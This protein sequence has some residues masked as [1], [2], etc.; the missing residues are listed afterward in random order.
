M[1]FM[2]LDISQTPD[3]IAALPFP[4]TN[5]R[6]LLQSPPKEFPLVRTK[7][8]TA[9]RTTSA[10]VKI[11]R[12]VFDVVHA[13]GAEDVLWVADGV[14]GGG[15][16]ETDWG[17]EEVNLI[18]RRGRTTIG[19]E[20]SGGRTGTLEMLR[21]LLD[22]AIE[23]ETHVV[24]ENRRA[25]EEEKGWVGG[26]RKR[27]EE[28][29]R[30][31]RTCRERMEVIWEEQ[32]DNLRETTEQ[33]E[34]NRKRSRGGREGS[35]G[36]RRTKTR[37]RISESSSAR[38]RSAKKRRGTISSLVVLFFLAEKD[39]KDEDAFCLQ[40]DDFSRLLR[41]T[42]NKHSIRP[43]TLEEMCV[44]TS[45]F[46]TSLPPHS[47]ALFRYDR[48][49][50]SWGKSSRGEVQKRDDEVGCSFVKK[51]RRKGMVEGREVEE[52]VGSGGLV[53][54]LRLDNKHFVV[55]ILR[56][57]TV[58]RGR[59]GI[60]PRERLRRRGLR[61][62]STKGLDGVA[63]RFFLLCRGD[64]CSTFELSDLLLQTSDLIVLLRNRRLK[65]RNLGRRVTK[66]EADLVALLLVD[67]DTLASGLRLA[68]KVGG[69]AVGASLEREQER[70]K[71][72]KSAPE[73]QT[74]SIVLPTYGRFP[75]PTLPPQSATPLRLDEG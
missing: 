6:I 34:S 5:H 32:R 57:V 56:G 16:V 74:D 50:R 67:G 1:V 7:S 51:G 69:A 13:G 3:P 73:V 62:S 75:P 70:G 68:V 41:K 26:V 28:V 42:T 11:L 40:R 66:T 30:G 64:L 39:G 15:G 47:K 45:L 27:V 20:G 54:L 59:T 12:L 55:D 33:A 22:E 72:R 58:L 19:S 24:V 9:N 8:L 17:R 36:S 46:S 44:A 65:L 49:G 71:G 63:A 53:P 23:V 29:L 2:L 4:S 60:G 48:P 37:C 21:N 25:D 38:R 61:R 18:W 10:L 31:G 14:G 52:R 43:R 35:M